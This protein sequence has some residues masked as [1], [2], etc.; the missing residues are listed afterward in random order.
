MT[1]PPARLTKK[2][3]TINFSLIFAE[4]YADFRRFK[5]HIT[6]DLR[7]SAILSL[8]TAGRCEHLREN[9][10]YFLVTPMKLWGQW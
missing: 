9:K 4:L 5:F 8:P 2:Y 6:R 10:K 1:S 7:N 3:I